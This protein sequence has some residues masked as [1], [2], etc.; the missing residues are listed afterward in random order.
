MQDFAHHRFGL[1][2]DFFNQ[3]FLRA[4]GFI[5]RQNLFLASWIAPFVQLKLPLAAAADALNQKRSDAS[6][7]FLRACFR[8]A[9]S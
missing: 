2:L 1:V 7:A 5:I 4:H 6:F 3:N 8:L 9:A